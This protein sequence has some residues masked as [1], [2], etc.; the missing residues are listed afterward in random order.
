MLDLALLGLLSDQ[1]LHGYELKKQLAEVAGS[2]AAVSFGS[3]YPALGRLEKAGLV[4][5][6]A[7]TPV[8]RSIPMTGSLGAEVAAVRAHRATSGRTRRT[9]KVYAITPAGEHRLTEL[10]LQPATDERTFHL[11]VAFCQHLDSAQRLELF[12]RRRAELAMHRHPSPGADRSAAGD[13]LF[14]RYR[15][16]LHDRE[17]AA[18]NAELSW[19]D[20]LI[21]EERNLVDEIPPG[22]SSAFAAA[23]AQ[24]TITPSG[25]TSQ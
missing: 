12:E 17:H 16:A 21:A 2:R 22:T 13:R 15:R 1:P 4:S 7:D 19:L 25:G 23:N 14:D 6:V 9:R 8:G 18:T 20:D 11:Q 10:L 24:A 5:T 3:L